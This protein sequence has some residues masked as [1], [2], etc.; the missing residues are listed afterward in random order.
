MQT[1][2]LFLDR[3][4]EFIERFIQA[5]SVLAPLVLLLV[6]EAGVPILVPGDIVLSYTGYNVRSA[7]QLTLWLTFAAATCAVIIGSSILFFLARKYGRSVVLRLGRF[8][9]VDEGRLIQLEELFRRYGVWTIIIGRHI[10][11]MRVPITIF[12]AIS[13]VRY[14]TFILSTLASTVLWIWL[15]LRLGQKYGA[16]IK[17]IL[18]QSSG[19]TV[20][21]LVGVVAIILS[22]HFYGAYREKGAKKP[23]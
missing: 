19:L 14:R 13:G 15:Y 23:S 18:S 6:E 1:V 16:N 20:A 21:A 10:P 7:G 22:L 3:Y 8:V 12:A 5:Q 11:G 9:F 4:T 17:H 2:L